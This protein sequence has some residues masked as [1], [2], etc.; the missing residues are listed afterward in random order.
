MNTEKRNYHHGGLREALIEAAVLILEEE[1]IP[2]MS[3]R[4]IARAAGVS[5]AAP[6]S[7]FANKDALLIEVAAYGFSQF[8]YALEKPKAMSG[9]PKGLIE[10]LVT[11]GV[12]YVNFAME[13]KALFQLMFGDALSEISKSESYLKEGQRAYDCI[14]KAVRHLKD[15]GAATVAAWSMVHGLAT[16]MVDQKIDFTNDVEKQVR[17]ILQFLNLK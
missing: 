16:L 3:L 1:G 2:K 8:S 6:Y 4:S 12:V 13:N 17:S 15:E 7:H 10:H 9:D 14:D 11:L 5:Q